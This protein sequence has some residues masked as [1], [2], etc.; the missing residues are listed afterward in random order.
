MKRTVT[1]IIFLLAVLPLPG[2]A[3]QWSVGTNIAGIAELGTLN[4]EASASVSRRLTVTASAGV[5]PWTFNAGDPD[6]QKEA[7]SQSY[8]AGVR[9]WPWHVYSGWWLDSRARY[10]EYNMG[11]FRGRETEEGDAVG[12][13]LGFGYTLMLLDNLNVEFG[14]RLWGGRKVYTTYACPVCG[15]VTDS[16]AKWFAA[17]ED[18]VLSL[19]Y[20]F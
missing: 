4:V 18:L 12:A 11:G 1:A 20:I 15:R 8:S 3:Q 14:A 5:N 7:R 2:L 19:V 17:P 9:W 10:M 6:A 13:S 16:G